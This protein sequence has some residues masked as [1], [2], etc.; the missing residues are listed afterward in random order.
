MKAFRFNLAA[1]RSAHE[2]VFFASASGGLASTLKR[3][4]APC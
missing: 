1:L 4:A 2:F 3:G